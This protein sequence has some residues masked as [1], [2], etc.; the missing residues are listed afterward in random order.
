LVKLILKMQVSIDGFVGGPNGE[1]AWILKSLDD[2]AAAWMLNTLWQAGVHIMGSHTFHDM[3]A[4]WPSSPEPFAAAMN[5]IPKVVFS[6]RGIGELLNPQAP[7]SRNVRDAWDAM[8]EKGLKLVSNLS[9]GAASWGHATVV[10]G[11]LASEIVRLKQQ[12]GKDILAHGGA[13]FAQSLVRQG[14]IDEYRLMVHPAALGCGLPLF[15]ALSGPMDLK[16]VSSTPFGAGV[17]ANVY[18]PA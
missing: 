4:Y 2:D 8:A 5:E 18:R 3:A 11:D 17:I 16:L 14:L 6:S 12:P 1:G 7:T 10:N 13:R 9:A 15:S